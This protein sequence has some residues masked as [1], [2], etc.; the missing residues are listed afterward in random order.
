MISAYLSEISHYANQ[1][2]E[3]MPSGR[4]QLRLTDE[5]GRGGRCAGLS[6]RVLDA[7]TGEEREVSSLTRGETLQASLDL[8]LG[9]ADTVQAQAGGGVN[10]DA[11]FIDK[12]FGTLDPENLQMAMDKLD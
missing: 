1:K 12:G 4:Y 5:G 2:L 11:Q 8:A 10:L 6:L 7:Y 3:L 9:V